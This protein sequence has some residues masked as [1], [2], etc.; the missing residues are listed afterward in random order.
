[1][2]QVTHHCYHKRKKSKHKIN[3]YH[4][5]LFI[6][7]GLKPVVKMKFISQH[8]Y[9]DLKNAINSEHQLISITHT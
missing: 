7:S 9:I 4:N 8:G 6:S 1:M 2:F 3:T 5:S